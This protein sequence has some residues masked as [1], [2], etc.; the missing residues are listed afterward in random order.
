MPRYTEDRMAEVLIET[1]GMPYLAARRLGCSHN[2]MQKRIAA[3]TRLQAIV[4]DQTGQML[5]TAELKLYQSVTNGE[6]GAIKYLLSTKGKHRGYVE[7]QEL[8]HSG[9]DGGPFALTVTVVDDRQ[10]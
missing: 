4:E 9:A 5:D 10:S 3:S 6:L 1:K 2:T 8:R 7:S